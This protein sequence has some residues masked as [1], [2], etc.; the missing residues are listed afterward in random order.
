MQELIVHVQRWKW[1][2][3]YSFMVTSLGCEANT[4]MHGRHSSTVTLYVQYLLN[5]INCT[6]M[7]KVLLSKRLSTPIKILIKCLF[8]FL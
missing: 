2:H 3:W 7:C 1:Q 4:P 8:L 6:P 5:Q